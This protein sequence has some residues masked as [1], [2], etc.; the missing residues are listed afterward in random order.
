MIAAIDCGTNTIKLLV[1]D[2]SDESTVVRQSR[3]VRLG[4]GVDR[5]GRLAPEAL[6]RAFAAIDEYA[7]IIEEAGV[8][9]IRFCATSA[10]RDSENAAEFAEGVRQRLGVE[11]EVL[12]GE[13]E[14]RLAF[15]G[16]VR[17]LDPAPAD[18]VLVVDIGGGSTELIVGSRASGPRSAYSMDIGSVRLHERRIENDP[19]TA[20]EIDAVVGDIDAALDA[21]PFDPREAASMVG[22]AGTITTVAAGVLGL[23]EYDRNRID[24]QRLAVADVHRTVERLVGMTVAER[25]ALGYVHPGRADVIDAGAL[26]LDRVLRRTTLDT[27][28]VAETDILDGIAWSLVEG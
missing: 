16:A 26:V 10:T 28:T 19:P 6:E 25:R 15:A 18:P 24:R 3:M 21:C 1:G 22:V 4:Q 9:R 2:P 7:A 14:A 17:F 27:M 12:S 8:E 20:A 23:E 11:P 13:E 5:T